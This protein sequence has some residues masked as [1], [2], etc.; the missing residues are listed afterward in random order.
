MLQENIARLKGAVGPFG[1]YT[2]GTELD[3]LRYGRMGE[4]ISSARGPRYFDA[5]RANRMYCASNQAAVT[6]GTALTATGVTS[7]LHNPAGSDVDVVV[8]RVGLSII[9]CTTAGSIVL[10][11][12]LDPS[13]AAVVHGTPGTP[14]PSLLGGA[15]GRALFDVACTLPSAPVAIA[16]LAGV[17]GAT[18]GGVANWIERVFD[19]S[20]IL[21]PGTSI[22]IQGITIVGT[23]LGSFEWE[24]IPRS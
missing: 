6:W 13:A 1:P 14:R 22:S 21:Q 4:L 23:G 8:H 12:N 9:T 24:E 20:L 19:G 16:V 10:A 11:A 5:C 7:H 17:S 15:A 2:A 18:A 3:R